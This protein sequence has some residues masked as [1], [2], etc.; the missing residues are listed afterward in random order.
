MTNRKKMKQKPGFNSFSLVGLSWNFKI[1]PDKC[2][3][4]E[5]HAS[6][7]W[8][9]DSFPTPDHKLLAAKISE[10]IKQAFICRAGNCQRHELC[11]EPCEGCQYCDERG[12]I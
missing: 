8:F 9:G 1:E 7:L 5:I 11:A 2:P 3:V 6:N 4:L 10:A 12:N